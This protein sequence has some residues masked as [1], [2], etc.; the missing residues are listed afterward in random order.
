MKATAQIFISYAQEDREKVESLYQKLSDVGF[1]PWMDTKDI[2]PGEGW[3]SKI[4]E[5]IQRSDFFL[6]CL[7]ASSVDK[8]GSIQKEIKQALKIWQEKLD[9]DIYLIPVQLEDCQVPGSLRDFQGVNLFKENGWARLVKAIQTGMKRLT[10]EES[11]PPPH[12][13]TLVP[14]VEEHQVLQQHENL[15]SITEPT[16]QIVLIIEMELKDFDATQQRWLQYA[17]AKFLDISPDSVQTT[18][19][20]KT[21]SVKVTIELPRQSAERLL[22]AHERKDSEL[23]E[24]LAPLVLLDLHVQSLETAGFEWNPFS[25]ID[26]KDEP[27]LGEYFIYPVGFEELLAKNSAVLYTPRGGGKTASKRMVE[28]LCAAGDVPDKIFSVTYDNFEEVLERAERGLD[29]ITARMHVEAILRNG[30]LLLF[31][32]LVQNPELTDTFENWM[33][34]RAFIKQFTDC[35]AGYRLNQ[36]LQ[37]TGVTK[38]NILEA[39]A[40]DN[41]DGLLANVAEDYHLHVRFIATLLKETTNEISLD[42]L[43]P[44]K[45]LK[46]F[47]DLVKAAGFDTLFVLIDNVDGLPETDGNPQACVRLLSALVG[48][49][50]LMSLSGVFFKFFLPLD[51]EPLL[52]RFRAFNIRRIRPVKV[53]WSDEKLHQV[54]QARLMAATQKSRSPIITSLDMV[55][56]ARLR[57]KI[58]NE[59][60]KYSKTPRD[61]VRLGGEVFKAYVRQ[62][63]VKEQI[64]V[65]E[66]ELALKP[67]RDKEQALKRRERRRLVRLWGGVS[68]AALFALISLLTYLPFLL[69]LHTPVADVPHTSLAVFTSYPCF[70][71]VGDDGKIDVTVTNSG[72]AEIANIRTRPVFTPDRH[73]QFPEG[74]IAKFDLLEAGNSS[75]KGISFRPLEACLLQ[76]DLEVLIRGGT[77]RVVEGSMIRVMPI[78]NVV[79]Y[80]VKSFLLSL[81]SVIVSGL[82]RLIY[83][84]ISEMVRK[85]TSPQT[86]VNEGNE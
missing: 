73:I 56:E 43:G 59:L 13:P 61:L 57:G 72:A 24:R 26:A 3:E 80:L 40:H 2:L 60:I 84:L 78:P 46:T 34:L 16:T 19:M 23:V 52:D 39:L 53:D 70:L 29:S 12:S 9:N 33:Y 62:I 10:K 77:R 58:D 11:T 49:A 20:Q 7:S 81:V 64:T 68:L 36:A 4:Q 67:E 18:S 51:T 79:K 44:T 30:L 6:V 83:Q 65:E 71:L 35:L 5:A 42:K 8:R 54:L 28:R 47:Y 1:K 45:L 63:P 55:S 41:L 66:L 48:T 76:F 21:S 86:T 15:E 27:Y 82:P 32:H 37:E 38:K 22:N 25:E 75:T 50:S 17:L 14:E 31:D 85:L 69:P 74:N